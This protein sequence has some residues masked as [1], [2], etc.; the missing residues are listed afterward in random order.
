MPIIL[1]GSYCSQRQWLVDI[2]LIIK[3]RA[4]DNLRFEVPRWP[5]GLLPAIN[6]IFFILLVKLRFCATSLSK[7]SR[8][9]SDKFFIEKILRWFYTGTAWKHETDVSRH[10]VL[11]KHRKGQTKLYVSGRDWTRFH[12]KGIKFHYFDNWTIE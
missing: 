12:K 10:Q 11:K 9:A 4:N 8:L 7:K 6:L 3:F 1:L 5:L 2:L